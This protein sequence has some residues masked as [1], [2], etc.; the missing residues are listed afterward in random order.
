MLTGAG[1][2]I[3]QPS[4][5]ADQVTVMFDHKD[6]IARRLQPAE[7]S[8]AVI[9]SAGWQPGGRF[10]R[11]HRPPR[12]AAE[13]SCVASRIPCNLPEDSVGAC[14]GPATGKQGQ[15]RSAAPAAQQPGGGAGRRRAFSTE[16]LAAVRVGALLCAE[17]PAATRARP[18]RG[19]AGLCIRHAAGRRL[20]IAAGP[21]PRV[22]ADRAA[23]A[24][25]D[26]PVPANV[27]AGERHRQ[28]ACRFSRLPPDRSGSRGR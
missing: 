3:D 25:T 16:L 15:D 19:L 7:G 22:P 6:R 23:S 18:N 27:E 28:G 9:P 17:P 24:S 5:L 12:K 13:E 26:R 11:C 10:V 21:A 8:T 20:G 1:A 2:D 14:G 4:G